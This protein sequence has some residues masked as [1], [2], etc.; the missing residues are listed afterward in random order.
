MLA[1]VKF[2]A[3]ETKRMNVESDSPSDSQSTEDISNDSL[4]TVD[5]ADSTGLETDDPPQDKPGEAKR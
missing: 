5:P 4:G 3:A 2:M 1:E